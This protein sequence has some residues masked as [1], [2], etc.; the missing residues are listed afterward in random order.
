M[1][2]LFDNYKIGWERGEGRSHM[3]YR[4]CEKLLVENVRFIKKQSD[5]L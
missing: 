2:T 1:S 4:K 5:M 3:V